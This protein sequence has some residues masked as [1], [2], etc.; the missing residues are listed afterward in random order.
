MAEQVHVPYANLTFDVGAAT[1]AYQ[2]LFNFPQQ[3]IN[4]II[5]LGGFH[6][7]QEN[8][9]IVGKLI[10]GSGFEDVVF[11]AKLCAS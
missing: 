6:L 11:Q 1:K 10:S 5:H 8:F 4:V 3:F 9:E 7:F 2:V